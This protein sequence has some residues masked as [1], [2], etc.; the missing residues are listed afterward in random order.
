MVSNILEKY[1]TI[2]SEEFEGVTI[3]DAVKNAIETLKMSKEELQI[4]I[5]YEG[6]PGLFGLKGQKPA[7]VK[8]YP[9]ILKV[10]NVIKFFL[11]KLLSFIQEKIIFVDVKIEEG[12]TVVITTV[13]SAGT[14]IK[15]VLPKD[16]HM[17]VVLLTKYF[18]SQILP[19]YKVSINFRESSSI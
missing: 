1:K 13:F 9:N 5:L 17:A 3:D 6:E 14:V 8:V 4:K 2:F 15:K 18:V 11:I 19:H 10:E 7:R 12:Q 16:V